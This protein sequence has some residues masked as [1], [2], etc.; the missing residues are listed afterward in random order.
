MPRGTL[1]AIVHQLQFLLF[2]VVVIFLWS[3]LACSLFKAPSRC[4]RVPSS[5]TRDNKTRRWLIQDKTD[6]RWETL[7]GQKMTTVKVVLQ[8][9]FWW[10]CVWRKAPY[11]FQSAAASAWLMLKWHISLSDRACSHSCFFLFFFPTKIHNDSLTHTHT[12]PSA[13]WL[14]LILLADTILLSNN[15]ANYNC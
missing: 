6:E 2:V 9:N 4:G 13:R 11:H 10:W 3:S 12:H 5:F 7:M 15:L 8:R 14:T 1:W